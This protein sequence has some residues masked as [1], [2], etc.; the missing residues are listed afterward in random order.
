VGLGGVAEGE[1]VGGEGL[2]YGEALHEMEK[3]QNDKH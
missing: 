3:S 1:G 2:A